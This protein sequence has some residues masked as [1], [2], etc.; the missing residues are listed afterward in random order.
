MKNSITHILVPTD[1][2]AFSNRAFLFACRLA[3]KTD[4]K[5]SLFHVVEPPYNFATAVKGMLEMMENNALSRMKTLIEE[6]DSDIV[7]DTQIRH[8]RTTREILECVEMEAVDLVVMGSRGQNALTRAVLGSVSEALAHELPIPLFLIPEAPKKPDI[9]TLIFTTDFRS[10]DPDNYLYATFIADFLDASVSVVHMS[11]DDDFNTKIRH[12]G[13]TDILRDTTNDDSVSIDIL[14]AKSLLQGLAEYV[15][16]HR[17]SA[18]V[19]NRYK[20]SIL[21]KLFKKDHTD[22]MVVYADL[23]LLIIPSGN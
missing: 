14:E 19:F 7:F 16:R 8:G 5:V 15:D 3:E 13:F 20:K 2:S 21:Q 17:N 22:E 23:P 6:T 9:S 18:L 12:L 11:A 1:F 4:A 10:N